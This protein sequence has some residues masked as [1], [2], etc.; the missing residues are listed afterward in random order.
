MRGVVSSQTTADRIAREIAARVR[1]VVSPSFSCRPG[2]YTDGEEDFQLA[3]IEATAG[4]G[5]SEVP[6]FRS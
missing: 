6:H 1:L 2:A 5:S 3:N 4:V